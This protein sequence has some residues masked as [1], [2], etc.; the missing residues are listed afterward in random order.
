MEIEAE[1]RRKEI[2]QLEMQRKEDE[3]KREADRLEAQQKAML[4]AQQKAILEAQQK[5]NLDQNF[6]DFR[7]IMR[8]M[9]KNFFGKIILFPFIGTRRR[10]ILSSGSILC[11]SFE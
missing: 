1:K 2:E 8:V 6:V 10:I 9:I 11:R 7:K 4:E 3:R 5:V